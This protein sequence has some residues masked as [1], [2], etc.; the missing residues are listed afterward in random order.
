MG[1]GG[2]EGGRIENVCVK[3]VCGKSDRRE[4]GRKRRTQNLVRPHRI[5]VG[6]DLWEK[7]YTMS[8]SD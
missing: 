7:G 4:G 2:R 8:V 5:I 3:V 1:K 6:D